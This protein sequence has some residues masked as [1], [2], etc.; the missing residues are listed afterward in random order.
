M[1]KKQ[2]YVNVGDQYRASDTDQKFLIQSIGTGKDP[3][4]TYKQYGKEEPGRISMSEAKRL[5]DFGRWLKVR[6]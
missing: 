3:V 1:S 2:I 4:L 5:I 6:I